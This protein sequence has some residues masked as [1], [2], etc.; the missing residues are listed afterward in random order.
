MRL[1]SVTHCNVML[2]CHCWH[3]LLVILSLAVICNR[4]FNSQHYLQQSFTIKAWTVTSRFQIHLQ[5]KKQ[6]FISVSVLHGLGPCHDT[7]PCT[8]CWVAFF[9]IAR[10]GVATWISF[11][12]WDMSVICLV[13]VLKLA[14]AVFI[15][16]TF[17]TLWPNW[18][19]FF[20][21]FKKI[22]SV[23]EKINPGRDSNGSQRRWKSCVLKKTTVCIGFGVRR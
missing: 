6:M 18:L 3:S 15:S 20:G 11:F 7:N 12:C 8:R 4:T 5:V 23:S 17:Q 10:N 9:R 13:I 16:L 2:L 19:N 14:V 1:K 21:H 22:R